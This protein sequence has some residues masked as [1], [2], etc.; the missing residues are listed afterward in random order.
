MNRKELKQWK[1]E[2]ALRPY[3]NFIKNWNAE[4]TGR[5]LAVLFIP[6][7]AWVVCVGAWA[8]N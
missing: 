4:A 2:K 8:I 1:R 3:K 6:V 7:G 5:L